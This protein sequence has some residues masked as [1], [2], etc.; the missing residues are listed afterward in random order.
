[1]LTNE[2]IARMLNE[3]ADLM[4]I[5]QEDGFRIRSYRNVAS[6]IENYPESVAEIPRDPS[7]KFTDIPGV[8]KGIAHV[9]AEITE[10]G[11]FERRDEA[12][13]R[14]PLSILELLKIQGLGPKSVALLWEHFHAST[15]DELEALARAGKLR[16]LPR[17]GEKLEEKVLRSIETYR[18]GAG[19]FLLSYGEEIANDLRNWLAAVAAD[20][21]IHVAGSYRRGKETIGD[22]DLLVET[23]DAE[24]VLERFVHAPGAGEVLGKGSN[25]ASV[26]MGAENIQVDM[27]ALPA[28]SLG[29][30]LQYFTGS[31]EHSIALRLRAVGR[32]LTLNEYG[33]FHEGDDTPIAN[34]RE[35]DVYH[36]LGLAW[37]PPELR[38]NTGEIE[39]AEADTLPVLVELSDIRGDLHM[40]T[41]ESD[42]H[43]TLEEM[44]QAAKALGY[45]YIAITDHSKSLAMTNGLDEK[46]A[47]AFAKKVEKLNRDGH[48]GIRVL[49]GLECD[50]LAD[51]RMDLDNE[52]L[53]AL[54]I[55]IGSVHSHMNQESAEMT[56]RLLRAVENPYMRVMGHPTGRVLL[57]REAFPF[58]FDAVAH[59]CAKNR[60]AME[61]N[62]SPERMDLHDSLIRA[63]QTRGVKFVVD[64]DAHLPRHLSNMKF[65]VKMARR[66]W[67]EKHEVLNTL[68]YSKLMK[69]LRPRPA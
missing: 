30:A 24:S 3:T 29:A 67:L 25:K 63:A 68:P 9:L 23:N 54:D 53:A 4:E 52:A 56:A 26:K 27:R 45:G 28:A 44:A 33:L 59:A 13:A 57:H 31:K 14:Y 6:A 35:E 50:I 19:R 41:V 34:A 5:A 40:H 43:A 49:A 12:L 47:I 38:E 32:K 51:G 11:S 16:D 69:A 22:L 66:G 58:D 18:Q 36:Q 55:V 42:G 37:I 65:G 21:K 15:I 2:R 64:T 48:L 20:E 17:M 8:G 10:R 60:V 61:I 62:G 1:M 7:K 39:R 46:R